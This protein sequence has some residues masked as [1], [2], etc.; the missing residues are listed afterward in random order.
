MIKQFGK[1]SYDT[2]TGV[3]TWTVNMSNFVRAGQRA[4]SEIISNGRRYRQIRVGGKLYL[5]H[6]LIFFLMTGR[7]AE[8]I[9]HKNTNGLDNS[10]DNL[11]EAT[12]SQNMANT[13]AYSNN[14]SG[15]KGVSWCKQRNKW[16]AVIRS[17]GKRRHLGHFDNKEIAYAAYLAAAKAL[18]KEFARA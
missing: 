5:E 3:L 4:G 12:Q 11:R 6:Q 14:T 2:G 13:R 10:W 16:Q 15:Y 8:R 17:N 1:L 9:D 18:N 7:W